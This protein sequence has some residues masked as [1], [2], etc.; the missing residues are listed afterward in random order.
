[1]HSKKLLIGLHGLA[2]VG[3]STIAA[4]LADKLDLKP[5]AIAQPVTEACAAALNITHHD[6][7]KLPKEEN[8]AGLRF[9]KRQLMQAIGR[10]LREG[11]QDFLLKQLERRMHPRAHMYDYLLSG[12][13]VTDIRLP[14]E[15]QWLR[16]HG[17]TLIHV[18]RHNAPQTHSDITE[19]VLP[20]G[21]GDYVLNNSDTIE[22]LDEKIKDLIRFIRNRTLKA[23]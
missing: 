16:D 4:V 13:L 2:Y 1:M 12:Y 20:I 10:S 17:G 21:S 8:L 6:F 14:A 5:Y 7:L 19:Q 18:I 11:D 9:T 15:A 22:E 23:A 3:K